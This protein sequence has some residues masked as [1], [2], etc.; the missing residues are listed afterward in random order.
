VENG[1]LEH[2]DTQGLDGLYTLRLSV[3]AGGNVRNASVPVLVDNIS[4]TVSIILPEPDQVFE[5]G[6]DE[7]INVQVDAQDNT[8]MDRVAFHLDERTLGH[9]T[10]APYTLRWVL[11]M[12]DTVPSYDMSLTD[13]VKQ[14]IG[15]KVIRTEVITRGEN[16]IF[17]HAIERGEEIT[18]T[19]VIEGPEGVSYRM[20]WPSGK[21]I[22]SDAGGYTE[23]H[24]IR[25]TAYDKAG[26]E[27][28][29]EPV[30]VH[31]IHKSE[32]EE[33]DGGE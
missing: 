17:T 27:M 32:E 26:N 29:S 11:A 12:S 7:W 1:V 33:E 23:T 16:R 22:T 9:T 15:D 20:T 5:L 3:A 24:R 2:W 6:E 14:V 25:V 4:P 21:V 18:M 28:E 30:K 19:E 10:V 8:S 31:V 13:P